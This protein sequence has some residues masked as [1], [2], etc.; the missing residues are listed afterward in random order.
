[1][2]T[3][4]RLIV[5]EHC[6]TVYRQR[7]LARGEVARCARCDAV[8]QRHQRLSADA[9][10][11][12][13]VAALVVFVIA[14]VTPIVSLGLGGRSAD[15]TLWGAVI[16]MWNDNTIVVSVLTAMTLFF[17]PLTQI[18]LYGWVLMFAR[19]GRRAPGFARV[20]VALHV[21]KPW[22]MIEVFM[23]GTLVAVVKASTYFDVT[24]RPGVWSFAALTVLVTVFASHDMRVLWD[25]TEE[26]HS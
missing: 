12:L 6:D 20:M 21:V 4:G 11:A 1:M 13:I 25:T 24:P 9:L 19:T 17:F 22:S 7:Q 3:T 14:N 15:T 18:L 5:C 23:L 10:F 8:L 26:R 2:D 16:T